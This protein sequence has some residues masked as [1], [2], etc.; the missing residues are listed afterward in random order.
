MVHGHRL[1]LTQ[2]RMESETLLSK[3]KIFREEVQKNDELTRGLD[4]AK[5][6]E[7]VREGNSGSGL[8]RG[9]Y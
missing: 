4:M 8:G 6:E 2:K 9:S 7:E 5:L 3:Q 1:Y